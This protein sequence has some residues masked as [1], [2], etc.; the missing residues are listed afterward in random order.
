M[1][2]ERAKLYETIVSNLEF[3]IKNHFPNI[4]KDFY[5]GEL[6]DLILVSISSDILSIMIQEDKELTLSVNKDVERTIKDYNHEDLQLRYAA[7]AGAFKAKYA[8]AEQQRLKI[9]KITKR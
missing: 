1:N 4:D 3:F 8:W 7:Q 9:L 6:A 2:I 5:Y